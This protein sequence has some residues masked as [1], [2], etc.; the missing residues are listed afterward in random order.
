VCVVTE[1]ISTETS[2]S[3]GIRARYMAS[4]ASIRRTTPN[5]WQVCSAAR[6]AKHVEGRGVQPPESEAHPDHR[7]GVCADMATDKTQT[8]LNFNLQPFKTF[9]DP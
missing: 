6:N 7:V 8:T 4:Q 3:S 5:A 9:I 2:C 1:V